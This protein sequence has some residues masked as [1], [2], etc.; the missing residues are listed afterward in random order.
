MIANV[1]T[2]QN[3]KKILKN[4]QT[5]PAQDHSNNTYY[6]VG[7]TWLDLSGLYDNFLGKIVIT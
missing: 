1:I 3:W 2:S 7:F 4:N 5:N 6:V